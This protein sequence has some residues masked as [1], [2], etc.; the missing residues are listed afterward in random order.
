[1]IYADKGLFIRVVSNFLENASEATGEDG[2]ITINACIDDHEAIII[3]I[4][5]DG[6][7]IPD[8]VAA[9]IFIPFFTT[10]KEGSGIGLPISRQIMRISNGALI[11]L[12]D[13]ERGIATFRM[14]FY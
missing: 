8:D 6:Q 7:L 4:S 10:K 9:H 1:M 3:D 5:N 2:H 11:L 14:I 12:S 13:K